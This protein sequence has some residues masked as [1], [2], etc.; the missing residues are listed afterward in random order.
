MSVSSLEGGNLTLGELSISN[1]RYSRANGYVPSQATFSSSLT[2]TSL[3][4]NDISSNIFT[5][6]GS[7]NYSLYSG[8][9]N[10]VVGSTN[11][12]AG[13]TLASSGGEQAQITVPANG[14]VQL[15][16]LTVGN[17]TGISSASGTV[18]NLT[19]ASVGL[20]NGAFG[21]S[22]SVPSSNVLSISNGGGEIICGTVNSQ[23]FTGGIASGEV[24]FTNPLSLP[25]GESSFSCQI[26][27]YPYNKSS[28]NLT[29][30]S[31]ITSLINTNGFVFVTTNN[32]QYTNGDD[33]S[34]LIF[35]CWFPYTS[36]SILEGIYW[37][38]IKG[39]QTTTVVTQLSP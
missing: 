29:G 9:G 5:I 21:T 36:S 28:A 32:L 11:G 1:E 22:L 24:T 31:I 15:S 17:N 19:S 26:P 2:S 25:E 27:Y 7:P 34:T 37:Q 39:Q 6:E 16:S 13:I 35:N 14:V 4:V 12:N 38:I 30:I 10:L 18:L 8:G 23:S 33:F 20:I 3:N